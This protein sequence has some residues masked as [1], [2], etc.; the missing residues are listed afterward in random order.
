M[1]NYLYDP[2]YQ[3]LHKLYKD[4]GFEK[5]IYE[6]KKMTS[7]F[8]KLSPILL[9][10]INL[11]VVSLIIILYDYSFSDVFFLST[12]LIISPL[13][14]FISVGVAPL[15]SIWLD[16]KYLRISQVY[17]VTIFLL[18]ALLGLIIN[19]YFLIIIAGIVYYFVWFLYLY[20]KVLNRE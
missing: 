10:I 17:A 15:I 9:I 14:G 18:I 8:I 7:V 6:F 11:I 13:I 20:F 3:V 19:N 12:L 5:S 1:I 2:L 16:V 4:L